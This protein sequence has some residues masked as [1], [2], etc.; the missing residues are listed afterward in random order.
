MS[1]PVPPPV[2]LPGGVVLGPDG[3]VSFPGQAQQDQVAAGGPAPIVPGVPEPVPAAAPP[4]TVGSGQ[5]TVDLERAPQALRELEDARLELKEIRRDAAQ[6]THVFPPG[7]D[8]VSRDAATSLASTAEGGPGSFVV[9]LDAG[10][11]QLSMLIEKVT[12]DIALYDQT[13]R[14]GKVTLDASART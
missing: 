11:K 8:A 13:E 7:Q 10:I 12:L 3:S 14:D 5:F 4:P 6:L 1:E 2:P 9:A